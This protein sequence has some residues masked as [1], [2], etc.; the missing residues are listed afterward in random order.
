M[1]CYPVYS[2][3]LCCYGY[4]L[5]IMLMLS[6]HTVYIV[7]KNTRK[8]FVCHG[9]EVWYDRQSK[10]SIKFKHWLLLTC[11]HMRHQMIAT[12]LDFDPLNW[13]MSTHDLTS[14]VKVLMWTARVMSSK[15]SSFQTFVLA[16]YI[17]EPGKSNLKK[18]KIINTNRCGQLI[19]NDPNLILVT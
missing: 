8:T 5:L 9:A 7:N 15:P 4:V 1:L 17:S 16:C 6:G 10:C 11:E 14:W 13:S 2:T 3:S 12:F 18:K 19:M